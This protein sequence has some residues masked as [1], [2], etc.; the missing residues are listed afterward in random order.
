MAITIPTNNYRENDRCDEKVVQA[1]CNA[2]LYG[3][4]WRFY[5][6]FS[7]GAY[8]QRN[9]L[10]SMTRGMFESSRMADNDC[11]AFTNAEMDMAV[12]ELKKAGYFLYKKYEFG[13]WLMY[14][15]SEKS[16]LDPSYK[17]ER[18]DSIPH[19]S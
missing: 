14:F 12:A 5:H 3:R 11:V 1:I 10:V 16:Y 9:S 8:R 7:E 15:F 4:A 18:A 2:F 6:P 17:A 19:F 13:S